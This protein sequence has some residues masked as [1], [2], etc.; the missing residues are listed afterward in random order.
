MSIST[1][2]Q[3][4]LGANVWADLEQTATS[5][6]NLSHPYVERRCTAYETSTDQIQMADAYGTVCSIQEIAVQ[7]GSGG[8]SRTHYTGRATR[9]Q[10]VV[11]DDWYSRLNANNE[12]ETYLTRTGTYGNDSAI[13]NSFYGY[14]DGPTGATVNV[15]VKAASDGSNFESSQGIRLE[16]IGFS[17]SKDSGTPVY[18]LAQTL[19]GKGFGSAVVRDRPLQ[20]FSFTIDNS[21]RFLT[22]NLTNIVN[23]NSSSQ[24]RRHTVRWADLRVE[25]Q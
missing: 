23:W 11:I 12:L 22:I 1:S 25:I 15:T 8:G 20:S 16:A 3:L 5:Q 2:G 21:H 14:L 4:R 24:R 6:S 18:Y 10:S 7:S 19:A 13:V 17:T 9:Y